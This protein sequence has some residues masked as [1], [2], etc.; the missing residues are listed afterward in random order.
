MPRG[1]LEV[2][3]V[4]ARGLENNDFLAKISPYA[5][6]TVKTQE[7]KSTV[8]SGKGSNPEWNESFLFTIS[9]D[10]VSE[11][12]LTIMDKDNFS[13]D[14]FVGEATIPLL[15]A[16]VKGTVSPTTYNIVNKE[17]EFHGGV[18]LGLNFTPEPG[19]EPGKKRFG[20]GEHVRRALVDGNSH[21]MGRRT[22]WMERTF[23]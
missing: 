21:L 8:L 19:F 20:S 3:L 18:K 10:E 4:D 12:H 17:K 5:V 2:V 15:P 11:L 13:A 9:D 22:R 16:F 14:D 1:T 23:L 7:K 6:L